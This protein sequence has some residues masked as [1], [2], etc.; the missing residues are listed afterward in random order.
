MNIQTTCVWEYKQCSINSGC[1]QLA[2]VAVSVLLGIGEESRNHIQLDFWKRVA[3]AA[4]SHLLGWK[5]EI[6][7]YKQ[8]YSAQLCTSEAWPQQRPVQTAF[9]I[10][11]KPKE[12]WTAEKAVSCYVALVPKKVTQTSLICWCTWLKTF[13]F[14]RTFLA[15]FGPSET[16]R[17]SSRLP[18]LL[19]GNLGNSQEAFQKPGFE[20]T[21]LASHTG[22]PMTTALKLR[23]CRLL[24]FA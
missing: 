21:P 2:S 16:L 3:I 15:A 14:A 18:N 17:E 22:I 1:Q 23:N 12:H 9:Q 8:T 7:Q 24:V 20:G 10:C 4:K 19:F 5:Q 6:L 13:G 11:D